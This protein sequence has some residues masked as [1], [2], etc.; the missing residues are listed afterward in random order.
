MQANLP[1]NQLLEL[2]M[3]EART[4]SWILYALDGASA[5]EGAKCRDI[6]LV[7]DGINHAVP[8]QKEM[9][10]SLKWLCQNNLAMK[11]GSFYKVTDDGK[12]FLSNARSSSTT[13]AGVWQV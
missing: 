1:A 8:S 10:E 5:N 6:S 13:I 11:V 12:L 9:N 7:A 4:L 3:Q 2:I